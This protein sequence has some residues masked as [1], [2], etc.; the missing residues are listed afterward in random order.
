MD[1]ELARLLDEA[2]F[3]QGGGGRWIGAAHAL[4]MRA[5]DR[6]YVPTLEELLMACDTQFTSLQYVPNERDTH[7]RWLAS[8]TRN[9]S[10]HF[11][12]SPAEAVA[13]LWL[14]LQ[15]D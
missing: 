12:S 8:S 10:S 6:A 15:K 5:A 7:R 3:P 13:K 9:A 1:Y 14:D 4:V 11:G 2:G